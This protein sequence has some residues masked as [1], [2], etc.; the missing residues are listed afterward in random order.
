MS[1]T[2][3][4]TSLMG[5][6]RLAPGGDITSMSDQQKARRPDDVIGK[7]GRPLHLHP[8]MPLQINYEGRV[9]VLAH[10]TAAPIYSDVSTTLDDSGDDLRE[11]P[12]SPYNKT[13][14]D[15]HKDGSDSD[16]G[17]MNRSSSSNTGLS[18][19]ERLRQ[20]CNKSLAHHS[21]GTCLTLD[22][23]IHPWMGKWTG[24]TDFTATCAHFL[25]N[26]VT[27]SMITSMII[28]S[29]GASSVTS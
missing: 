15:D 24:L 18:S 5:Q 9:S 1:S 20:I 29:S 3:I 8:R 22:F 2:C 12:S 17:D 14:S 21:T 19:L 27:S 7:D 11:S 13:S 16:G 23:W 6:P 4:P 26:H 10:A 25:A 28:T